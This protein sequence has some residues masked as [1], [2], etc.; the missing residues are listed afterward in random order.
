MDPFV[1]IMLGVVGG[2]VGAL[3]L[4]GRFTPGTG[5]DQLDWRPARSPEVEVQNEIDD[6]DQMLEAANRRRRT[7]G[8]AELTEGAL[9]ATVAEDLR[10]STRL[11]DDYL[12]DLEVIQVLEV[13]NRRRRE[14]GQPE[15]TLDEFRATLPGAE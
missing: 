1:V 14:R 5:A 15:L 4:I 11:R 9:H 2:L 6:L 7:R 13:K 3:L 10:H 12:G 8:E